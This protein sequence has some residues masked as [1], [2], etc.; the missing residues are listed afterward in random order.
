MRWLTCSAVIILTLAGCRGCGGEDPNGG[1]GAGS[2]GMVV[3]SSSAAVTSGTSGASAASTMSTSST[4]TVASSGVDSSSGMLP[5]SGDSS[6]T[7]SSSAAVV[8]MAVEVAPAQPTL[9]MGTELQLFATAVYSDGTSL[10]VTTQATWSSSLMTAATVTPG[11]LVT[12]LA[13]GSTQVSALFDGA[14]GSTTVTVSSAELSS[15]ELTPISPT[16]ASGTSVPLVATGIFSDATT[17]DLT[18]QAAWSSSD[19]A[20][21]TVDAAGVVLGVS[22][23]TVTITATFGTVMGTTMVTVSDATLT[24]LSVTPALPTAAAGTRVQLTA[25]GTFSDGTTQDLSSQAT[26]MSSSVTTATVNAAGLATALVAGTTTI[27]AAIGLVMDSTTLTVTDAALTVV[28]ITPGAPVLAAGGSVQLT[29][30]A[31][32][33]DNSTADVSTQVLWASSDAAVAT[34]S[35]AP[36]S[37]G[38]VTAVAAG[39]AALTATLNGMTGSTPVTATAGILTAVTVAPVL[40]QLLLGGTLQFTA[41]GTYSDGSS[42]D[43][44]Q[45]V[46]WTS[47]DGAV[48]SISN[49]AGTLGLAQGVAAG[50]ATVTATLDGVSDSTVVT[51]YVATLLSIVVTPQTTTTAVGLA[52]QFTATGNYSDGSTVDLTNVVTWTSSEPAVAVTRDFFRRTYVDAGSTNAAPVAFCTEDGHTALTL[53]KASSSAGE[54]NL[55]V[56]S[57]LNTNDT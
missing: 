50:A 3:D 15:I 32:F 28:T 57:Q 14:T 42:L 20:V 53:L 39:E 29:A 26:W 47:S 6:G 37:E 21:A 18:V 30:T 54:I 5:S 9:A 1:T 33:S 13:A 55:P 31:T 44:T 51:V 48:A 25:T 27:S 10:D 8:L 34:I 19:M 40:P 41:T 43:I 16:V 24:A 49:A 22:A 35:N 23:G 45:Q 52:Q 4:S 36:G 17:Q 46:T 11:G 56:T 38:L 12:A 2:S 7:G